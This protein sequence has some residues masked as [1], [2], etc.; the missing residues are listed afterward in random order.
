M[1]LERGGELTQYM[2]GND[3][4]LDHRRPSTEPLF[5]RGTSSDYPTLIEYTK[6]GYTDFIRFYTYGNQQSL[7]SHNVYDNYMNAIFDNQSKYN[8][9]EKA[10]SVSSSF[11]EVKKMLQFYNYCGFNIFSLA[12]DQKTGKFY[13]SVM[14]DFGKIQVIIQEEFPADLGLS[15]LSVTSVTCYNGMY[16]LVLTVGGNPFENKKQVI[17]RKETRPDLDLEINRQRL[18]GKVITSF[19]VNKLKNEYLV[20]MTEMEGCEQESRWFDDRTTDGGKEMQMWS[21]DLFQSR[22]LFTTLVCEDPSDNQSFYV[23]T[24]DEDRN[25]EKVISASFWN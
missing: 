22:K 7:I 1:Y 16:F 20:V 24:S 5:S 12:A 18:E 2:T 4:R 11:R 10:C 6:T 3:S 23:K 14:E 8:T 19:C 25:G 13:V 21:D 17:F 9:K 15:G